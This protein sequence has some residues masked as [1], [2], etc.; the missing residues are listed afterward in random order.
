MIGTFARITFKLTL[1]VFL[2]SMPVNAQPQVS[3]NQAET[4]DDSD[5]I[6]ITHPGI[7]ALRDGKWLW[8]DHLLNLGTNVAVNVEFAFEENMKVKVS[9]EQLENDIAETFRKEGITPYADPD[10]GKPDLPSFH[11]LVMAYPIKN[12][13]Y[14]YSISAR[15]FEPVELERIKLDDRVTM[16]AITWDRSSIHIVSVENFDKDVETSVKEVAKDFVD[17]Y[18][19]FER[20]RQRSDR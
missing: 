20:L 15:L 2:L 18:A 17:R 7:I 19:F 3:I 4:E 10:P 12:K 11:V 9:A 6:S 16:Q 14:T 5:T 13:G 8:S 1:A